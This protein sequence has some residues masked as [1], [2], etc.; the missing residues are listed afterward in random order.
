MADDQAPGAADQ[1]PPQKQFA[2]QKVYLRDVSF[3]NPDAPQVYAGDSWEPQLNLGLE[4]SSRRISEGQFEVVLKVTAEAKV[5]DKTAYLA[6][7]QQAGVIIA[8]GFADDE[9]GPML[10][11]YCP[12]LLFP[13]AREEI[14]SLV[15]KGGFP[16]LLLEPINFDALYAQQ[17]GDTA[18]TADA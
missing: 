12:N 15:A 2:I 13:F 10:G 11:S 6:E 3:E 1:Q 9:L 7:V 4:S 8:Q 18:A 16:Q 17:Q 5:N 14:A